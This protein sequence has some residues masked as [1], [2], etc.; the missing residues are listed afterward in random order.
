MVSR[1]ISPTAVMV[2]AAAL[3][4]TLKCTWA[5]DESAPTFLLFSPSVRAN[6]MGEAL[7]AIADPSLIFFNPAALGIWS[8]N[9]LG[10]AG[11]SFSEWGPGF[12]T[13][14][15]IQNM[16]IRQ[17]YMAGGFNLRRLKPNSPYNLSLGLEYRNHKMNYGEV[18]EVDP[19]GQMVSSGPSYEQNHALAM[20][21]GF[22]YGL[23]VGIGATMGLIRSHISPSHPGRTTAYDLGAQLRLPLVHM[24]RKFG[25]FDLTHTSAPFAV[26]IT[27]SFGLA[28]LSDGNPVIYEGISTGHTLPKMN[29]WGTAVE[30]SLNYREWQL[31]DLLWSDAWNHNQVEK[32]IQGEALEIHSQG[33][34]AAFLDILV[35]RAGTYHTNDG[36]TSRD[37]WGFTAQTAGLTRAFY[38]LYLKESA[39]N[40]AVLEYLFT[41]ANFKYNYSKM[42][43]SN[44]LLN[45]TNW[46]EFSLS[47]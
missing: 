29:R 12:Q 44:E 13:Q 4:V 5:T 14:F 27:P 42:S 33:I 47:F 25:E 16:W 31:L 21:L 6:G 45:N 36:Q 1:M 8:L 37:T 30:F 24:M 34:E 18:V 32:N 15:N 26:E 41:H 2:L 46:W 7:V 3:S 38:N 39:G 43:T 17:I 11:W 28:R 35:Y 23:E 20:G 19:Y 22:E 10:A 40:S 9:N